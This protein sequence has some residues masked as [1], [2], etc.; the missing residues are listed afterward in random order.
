MLEMAEAARA[1]PT[2]ALILGSRRRC[3]TPYHWVGSPELR[4]VELLVLGSDGKRELQL[5]AALGVTS[6]GSCPSDLGL[7]RPVFKEYLAA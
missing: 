2:V 6:S 4:S 7:P 1:G 5:S 3:G